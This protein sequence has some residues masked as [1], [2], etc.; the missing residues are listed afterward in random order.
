MRYDL[1]PRRR[2]SLLRSGP[3]GLKLLYSTSL[4]IIEQRPN[5]REF[6]SDEVCKSYPDPSYYTIVQ[7]PETL[8]LDTIQRAPPARA[9]ANGTSPQYFPRDLLYYVQRRDYG[10]QGAALTA[11]E[12]QCTTIRPPRNFRY[13]SAPDHPQGANQGTKDRSIGSIGSRS[14]E[15]AL[16]RRRGD[17]SSTH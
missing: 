3:P 15:H 12:G 13:C 6:S 16:D 11:Q 5:T 17:T 2:R 9:G 7:P 1:E 10:G 8:D 4:K 14:N